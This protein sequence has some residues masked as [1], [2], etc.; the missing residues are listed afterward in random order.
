MLTGSCGLSFNL[1]LDRYPQLASLIKHWLLD[2]IA[3]LFLGS[4]VVGL[5]LVRRLYRS[6][7][8][9]GSLLIPCIS[10]AWILMFVICS[11]PSFV[12]PLLT[13]LEGRYPDSNDCESGSHIVVLSGGVDSRAES[14]ESFERMSNATH[15]RAVA[16]W[17]LANAEPRIRLLVAGGQIGQVTEAEVVANYWRALGIDPN[18]IIEEAESSNTRENAL[19]AFA[20][21]RDEN[22]TGPIRL[23]TS[24]LHMPRAIRSFRNVFTES[25][26]EFC[27]VSVDRQALLRFSAWAWM[28]QST[29]LI[30]FGKWLHE[31]VAL[32]IY[33]TRGWI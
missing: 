23:I 3:L 1:H 33:R 4:V 2:P 31:I 27:R 12:N 30:K 19:Q 7:A 22:V 26:I 29:A 21:L 15:V 10:L 14:A 16:A 8:G 13:T 25:G 17:R 20:L 28:P 6:G 32:L 5:I 9:K 24:A 18:R 11:S